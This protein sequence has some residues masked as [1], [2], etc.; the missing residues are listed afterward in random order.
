[1][2]FDIISRRNYRY[3]VLFLR[4]IYNLKNIKIEVCFYDYDTG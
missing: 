1:M 2:P 4:P 3:Y